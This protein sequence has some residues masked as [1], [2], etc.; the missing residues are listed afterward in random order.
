MDTIII[1]QTNIKIE[2][3]MSKLTFTRPNTDLYLQK[4]CKNTGASDWPPQ[5]GG[6]MY[7]HNRLIDLI[8]KEVKD[9]IKPQLVNIS[10]SVP[11]HIIMM[12]ITEIV[13]SIEPN[14][15]SEEHYIIVSDIVFDKLEQQMP[16]LLGQEDPSAWAW[17]NDAV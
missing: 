6:E 2:N 8:G 4:F 5:P 9:I 14:G 11:S 10:S 3:K 17:V 12:K 16:Q 1:S 7:V 13:Q 15:T